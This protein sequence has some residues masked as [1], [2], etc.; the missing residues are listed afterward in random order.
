[1]PPTSAPVQKA[2]PSPVT[3]MA[4]TASLNRSAAKC[5]RSCWRISQRQRV[6]LLGPVQHHLRHRAFDDQID[7][8]SVPSVLRC[9]ASKRV[10][11][12]GQGG[13][14]GAMATYGRSRAWHAPFEGIRII[15]ITHV[16]AGPFAAY[17]LGRAG[18]RRDQG[19][20][21]GR[22]R[23]EPRLRQRQRAE[24]CQH[25]HRVS[26][27]GV[28]QALD[29]AGSEDRSGARDPAEAGGAPPMCWWRI[30]GPG[31][32]EALGLGY[33]DLRK[34]NPRL[35]YASFSAFGQGGPRRTQTAYDH[36]IQSTSGI[37]AMTGTPEMQSDQ[38]RRAGDRLRHRDDGR[39]RAVGG[40]VP[41]RAHRAGPAHRH[42]DAGRGDDPDGLAPDRLSAQRQASE[43]AAATSSRMPPTARI[44]RRTGW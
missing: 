14:V 40:V 29:H 24:P 31:A 42:G 15:D 25:G 12:A 18:R 5:S 11:G 20:T 16:L 30:I 36:V 38:D 6:Q 26:D 1:M 7:R 13:T 32:F 44:R 37:M 10:D 22:S 19:G 27:P 35:I 23:P 3:M 8:H 9:A 41:A 17:Q 43:A 39:L 4:R 21:S 34:I 2:R 33:E 28:E